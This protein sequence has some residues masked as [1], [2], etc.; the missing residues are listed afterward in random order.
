MRWNWTRK[1]RNIPRITESDVITIRLQSR[2]TNHF[3]ISTVS[4]SYIATSWIRGERG[5]CWKWSVDCFLQFWFNLIPSI[6]ISNLE[7]I[8]SLDKTYDP[9]V[10]G[11]LEKQRSLNQRSIILR[12]EISSIIINGLFILR[13]K[14]DGQI[15]GKFTGK[16]WN[17]KWNETNH[18][19]LKSHV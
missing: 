19:I 8:S 18:K 11:L 1:S 2:F 12:L 13:R 4:F 9:P 10:D 16:K 14:A 3:A 15:Y 5:N 7:T 6:Q 17:S